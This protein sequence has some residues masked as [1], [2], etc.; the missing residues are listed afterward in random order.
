MSS[1][2]GAT[3]IIVEDD[4]VSAAVLARLLGQLG[5]QSTVL[6]DYQI[7]DSLSATPHPSVIFLDLEMPNV[8]G[9]AVLEI[10]RNTPHLASVPVVAYT[11]HLSHMRETQAAGFDGFLGKPLDVDLFPAQFERI[12]NGNGVWEAS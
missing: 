11:T 4:S 8:N 3:A 6:S 12:M 5:V 9:Y 10:I 7:A 2:E 1:F